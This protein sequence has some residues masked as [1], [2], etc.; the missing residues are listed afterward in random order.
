MGRSSKSLSACLVACFLVIWT[1]STLAD[2]ARTPLLIYTSYTDQDLP[3]IKKA[4][5]QSHPD[6]EVTF[7]YD[8]VGVITARLL[9]EK[10]NRQADLVTAIAPASMMRLKSEGM[11]EGYAPKGIERLDRKFVDRDTP[12]RWIGIGIFSSVV[13]VNTIEAKAKNLPVPSSWADL[14][15]PIYRGQVLMANPNFSDAALLSVMAWIQLMGEERAWQFMDALDKNIAH[16][17]KSSMKG[18]REVAGG[19][20]AVAIT[21]D[22]SAARERSKGAPIDILLM[23]EGHGWETD[24]FAILKGTP[25]LAA[26]QAFADWSISDEAM[27]IYARSYAI[28][29]EPAAAR[30]IPGL[31]ASLID[32]LIAKDVDWAAANRERVQAE[33]TRRYGIRTQ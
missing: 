5:E 28:L 25:H 22:M 26:A 1:H 9:A 27:R 6:I 24:A 8:S 10:N 23:S 19:E 3:L 33:W 11:L 31:P 20:F 32:R 17:T 30:P 14:A 21:I 29:S 2:A 7:L 12:P 15:N 18:L 4:F 13:A 16:Y